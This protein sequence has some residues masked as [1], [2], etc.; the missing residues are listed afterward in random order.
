MVQIVHVQG[1]VSC[2]VD[3]GLEK[4]LHGPWA[5]VDWRCVPLVGFYGR[6]GLLGWCYQLLSL[7]M[8]A[9]PPFI[10]LRLVSPRQDL[11]LFLLRAGSSTCSVGAS[12]GLL[13]EAFRAS[14]AGETPTSRAGAAV[15]TEEALPPNTLGI[16]RRSSR[17]I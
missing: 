1:I 5:V 2:I 8:R 17:S 16:P 14:L 10:V 6:L 7:G 13:E 11:H 15:R 9:R 3:L 4:V 12:I